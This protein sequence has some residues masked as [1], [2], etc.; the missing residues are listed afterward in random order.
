V[1]FLYVQTAG[2]QDELVFDGD[3]L[4]YDPSGK[5]IGRGS[6]FGEDLI[7]LDLEFRERAR[8]V[9]RGSS[10]VTISKAPARAPKRPAI[11]PR[12]PRI[13][14]SPV[15]EVYG[16]LLLGTRD[17][18]RKNGFDRAFIGLSGGIDSSLTAVIAADALGPEN[19][20]GVAMPSRYSSTES[21]ED[22]KELATNLGI[23]FRM[24]PIDDVFQTFLDALA[25][26]FAGTGPDVTE[27]NLQ[28]R[29]RGTILM[30]FSNKFRPSLVLTT[31]NKSELAVG[32]STLYGDMAGGFGVLKDVPK[33]LVYELAAWRNAY[34][35]TAIPERVFTKA[36]SAELRPGQRDV[37]SLPPYETLDPI[38]SAYVEEQRSV[39]EIIEVGYDEA[40]VRRV[41]DMIDRSEYKRRQA[42]PGIKITHRA[43]GRD[44]R[45]P[46]TN[47]FRHHPRSRRRKQ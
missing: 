2:G 28:A 32:Y 11:T 37:D 29:I 14:A 39:R 41:V 3:S 40:T 30:S 8:A 19:V 7:L 9:R 26:P 36:P 27:E 4:A 47:R 35:L 24:V 20:T 42:P 25:E 10:V 15:E 13:A 5:L 38:L 46:I 6:Q 33:T 22:A 45:L 17:Y 1:F 18:V 12:R 44:W 43:F 34:G 23:D 16:A 31:G 21:L